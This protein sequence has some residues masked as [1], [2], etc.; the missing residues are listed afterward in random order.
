MTILVAISLKLSLLF[1]VIMSLLFAAFVVQSLFDN[2]SSET[3]LFSVIV[4]KNRQKKQV[5]YGM[6]DSKVNATGQCQRSMP[7]VKAVMDW[8]K[9]AVGF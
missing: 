2:C 6:I 5:Q 9:M 3:F 8:E 7:E 1:S 4:S